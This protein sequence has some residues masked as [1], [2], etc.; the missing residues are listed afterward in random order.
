MRYRRFPSREQLRQNPRGPHSGTVIE[1]RAP[2]LL[3]F[4]APEHTWLVAGQVTVAAAR[5]HHL[6]RSR[7][8]AERSGTSTRPLVRSGCSGPTGEAS[9][10]GLLH[11]GLIAFFLVFYAF[12][13]IYGSNRLDRICFILAMR[14]Y[15]GNW[16]AS[17]WCFRGH[18]PSTRVSANVPKASGLMHETWK[19]SMTPSSPRSPITN[20][21][22]GA[23]CT[24]RVG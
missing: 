1:I 17:V 19:R 12:P 21:G 15:A 23:P 18:A 24:S 4:L 14:Y 22:R 7:R 11:P 3:L 10:A 8:R 6:A 16:P 20:S 9:T 5:G 13:I 2:C